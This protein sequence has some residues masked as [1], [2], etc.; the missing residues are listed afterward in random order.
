MPLKN[1]T[2]TKMGCQKHR[3][4]RIGSWL[5]VVWIIHGQ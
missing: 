4:G 1:F 5:N 2:E 3:E